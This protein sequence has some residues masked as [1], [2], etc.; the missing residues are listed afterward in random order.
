MIKLFYARE[1]TKQDVR[2]SAQSAWIRSI[3][4]LTG[5]YIYIK[6]IIIKGRVLLSS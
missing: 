3:I 5:K 6:I 2:A 4:G 1:A